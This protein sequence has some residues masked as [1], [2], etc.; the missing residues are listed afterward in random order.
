M[1]YTSRSLLAWLALSPLLAV[2][3]FPFVVMLTTALKPLP[4]VFAYPSH[5][6]PQHPSLSS[7]TDMCQATRFALALRNSL[8]I[9]VESTLATLLVAVPAAYA[10]ARMSFRLRAPYRQFL[11]AT[12]MLSPILLV[13]GLYR[14][15]A[16]IPFGDG[17][18]LDTRL[19]I[20][21]P[22]VGFQMAFSVWMLSSYFAAI[23]AAIEE[24]AWMDGATRLRTIWS[25]FLPLALP[26]IAVTGLVAF[27]AAWNEFAI[28]LTLLRDPDRQTVTIQVVNLIAGRYTVEWNQVMAATLVAT[29]PVA[30]LFTWLQ[31][32]LVR[33]LTFGA[34]Q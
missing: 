26:A 10:V 13:L 7:F 14:L 31:R 1:S 3:L 5:W 30:L 24:A 8:E 34:I 16:M 11:L 15:M 32:Y 18:L 20:I 9:A 29:V 22:Y 27:V 19:A 23:P 28:A 2:S 25:I 12:Q 4:E 21:I 17:R 6:L 33:G